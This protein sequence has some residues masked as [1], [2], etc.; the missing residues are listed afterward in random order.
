MIMLSKQRTNILWFL[1]G[2]VIGGGMIY[3]VPMARNALFAPSGPGKD[4]PLLAKRISVDNPNDVLIAFNP[5][6]KKL[7]EIVKPWGS[8]FALYFEYLPT[9]VTIGVNEKE[10]YKLRSLIKVPVVMALY[11][12][13]DRQGLDI[14]PVVRIEKRHLDRGFGD[15]WERGEGAQIS[16]SEAARLALVDSDNTAIG[17]LVDYIKLE[18]YQDVYEGLDIDFPEDPA[19]VM[20][21]A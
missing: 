10:E 18:D 13:Y 1:A 11:R 7:R 12:M 6:R 19:N 20:L 5:L 8:S 9:G 17:V 4:Y 16:L 21:S 15:L 2:L 3:G 14:D